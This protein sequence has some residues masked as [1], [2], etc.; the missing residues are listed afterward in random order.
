MNTADSLALTLRP[1]TAEDEEFLLHL[2]G[3]TR[4]E[5]IRSWGWA[6]AQ[7][8][9]FLKMQFTAR[10]RSYQATFPDAEYLLILSNKIPIGQKIVERATDMVRLIDIAL[11]P[12]WRGS[13]IGSSLLKELLEECRAKNLPLELKVLKNNLA[14]VRLY[15]RMGFSTR[16]EDEMYRE[17]TRH[18]E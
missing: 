14:A 12:Q 5:E 17:M 1:I 15:E 18:P 9:L 7:A 10:Q 4:E 8:Q 2:Y 6:E 16:G 3:T 13:G 11:L